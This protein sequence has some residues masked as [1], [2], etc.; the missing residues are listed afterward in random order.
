MI[1]RDAVES[2]LPGILSIYNAAIP[3]RLATADTEP[4]TRAEPPGLVRRARCDAP[5][6]DSL[7]RLRRR[8]VG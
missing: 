4:V 5:A 6:L 1:I 8:W 2:D 7:D 3:G